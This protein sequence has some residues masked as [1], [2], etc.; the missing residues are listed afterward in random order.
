[1]FDALTRLFSRQTEPLPASDP[2]LSVAALLIHLAAV[3]GHMS[4]DERRAIR[5]GL[6][7]Q[8]GLDDDAV[9]GL[10]REATKRD[11][12]AVDL[13]TFTSGLTALD[14]SER[15]EIIELMWRVVFTDSTNQELEDNMV[16]RVAELI[17]V[18]TR[19]RTRLRSRIQREQAEH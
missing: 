8:Y 12:E 1:M 14:M 2:R 5:T 13:Y 10:I 6:K 19:D 15:I 11:A 7:R 3:D 9:D 18:S 4:A 17:G 16:W